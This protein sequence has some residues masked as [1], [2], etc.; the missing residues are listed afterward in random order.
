[1]SV[2]L[3]EHVSWNRTDLDKRHADKR[4]PGHLHQRLQSLAGRGQGRL[5]VL[6]DT[7]LRG[8]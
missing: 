6:A 5:E 8:S 2:D 3:G 7:S 4:G 1:M